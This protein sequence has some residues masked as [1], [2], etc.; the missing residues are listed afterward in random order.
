MPDF[1]DFVL[2]ASWDAASP[3]PLQTWTRAPQGQNIMIGEGSGQNSSP[4]SMTAQVFTRK[5]SEIGFSQPFLDKLIS[6]APLF[7]YRFVFPGPTDPTAT[8]V[9]PTHLEVAMANFENDSFFCLFRYGLIDRRSHCLLFLK[10]GDY[11]KKDLLKATDFIPWLD[12]N[13]EVLQRHPMLILNVILAFIQGREYE[14]VEWRM[15]LY[16][17]E[18]RLGVTRDGTYLNSSGYASIDHDFRLLNADIAGFVKKVADTELSA[19]TVLE[20]AK[21]VQRLMGICE[22]LQSSPNNQLRILSEQREELQATIIRAE[23]Y[24]KHMKMARDVLQSLTAVLYNRI[25]KQD[26]DSMK[27]IAVVTLVFLPATFISAIFSTGIFNFHATESPDNPRTVSKYGWV[28]LIACLLSTA[29]TLISW[30]CWYRWGR[31]WLEKLNFSR[32]HS[33]GT[34]KSSNSGKRQLW[35]RGIAA[36]PRLRRAPNRRVNTDVEN[37]L[38]NPDPPEELHNMTIPNIGVSPQQSGN[39]NP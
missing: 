7:E 10:T 36:L 15:D 4:F 8:A 38:R 20:H 1:N 19:S 29:L 18:S 21:S 2:D 28:Y 32:I 24:L 27:T 39:E 22:D 9:S 30:S 16:D 17:M 11:L 33:H 26:T 12:N 34:R 23:L 3:P 25:S 31:V 13:Q 5:C 35:R 14:F 37:P 6:R